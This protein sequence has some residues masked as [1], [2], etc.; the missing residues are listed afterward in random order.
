MRNLRRGKVMKIR[1]INHREPNDIQHET[2]EVDPDKL[3]PD[4]MAG[5][6]KALDLLMVCSWLTTMLSEICRRASWRFKVDYENLRDF[7]EDTL[8]NKISTITNPDN[9]P[10]RPRLAAWCKA[11]ARNR[12]LYLLRRRK[13]EQKYQDSVTHHNTK[14]IR[15]KKRILEPCANTLSP[16]EE[17]L[18]QQQQLI[19]E[20]RR[21]AIAW[22][23]R[24][25]VNSF[26]AKKRRIG[27]LWLERKSPAQIIQETGHAPSTV[28]RILR[29]IERAIFEEIGA[30][31]ILKKQP[32][33]AAGLQKLVAHGLR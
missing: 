23:A 10:S 24:K 3:I 16:E 4:A 21:L 6:Q 17:L 26:P 30:E 9:K 18:N 7:L 5:D 14:I 29:E 33:L 19:E 2:N 28:Y 25:V 15:G 12:S 8:R 13:V 32:E 27:C 11:V 22:I 1:E 31:E 20:R